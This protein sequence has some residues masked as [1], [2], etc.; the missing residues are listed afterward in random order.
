M[1]VCPVVRLSVCTSVCLSVGARLARLG[2][3]GSVCSARAGNSSF[4]FPAVGQYEDIS[5][6]ESWLIF[7]LFWDSGVVSPQLSRMSL[8]TMFS[9]CCSARGPQQ[10]DRYYDKSDVHFCIAILPSGSGFS[11]VCRYLSHLFAMDLFSPLY[12]REHESLRH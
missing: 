12:G 6:W 2:V 11:R 8:R 5:R 4:A 3:S 10:R 9:T 1:S 7:F